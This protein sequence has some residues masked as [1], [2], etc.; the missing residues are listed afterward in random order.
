MQYL[1]EGLLR[2]SRWSLKRALYPQ[3]EPYYQ[4]SD[5]F[6]ND[7]PIIEIVYFNFGIHSHLTSTSIISAK[8]NVIYSAIDHSTSSTTMSANATIT[9]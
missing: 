4:S 3:L 6:L 2:H 1:E 7:S 8:A 5:L 9:H